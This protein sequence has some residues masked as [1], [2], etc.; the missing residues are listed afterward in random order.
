MGQFAI[1]CKPCHAMS[2]CAMSCCAVPYHA[3]H[4]VD[5]VKGR[6]DLL[7]GAQVGR[8]ITFKGDIN[9]PNLTNDERRR[10]KRCALP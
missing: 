4:N 8:P 2:C 6:E 7:Y 5:M 9:N 1:W 3:V 10:I